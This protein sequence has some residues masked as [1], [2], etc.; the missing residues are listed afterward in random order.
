LDAT[1]EHRP[2]EKTLQFELEMVQIKKIIHNGTFQIGIYFGFNEE[3]KTKA[4]SIG[5][6]WSQTHRCWYVPYN[7]QSYQQIRITYDSIEIISGETNNRADGPAGT[8]HE[9]VRIATNNGELLPVHS[10]EHKGNGPEPK[11]PIEYMGIN[12]KYWILKVPYMGVTTRKL[13]AIKG[14]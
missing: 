5:A 10:E 6:R 12:G 2:I 1:I 11:A 9:T 13:M 14:V 8:Q 7:K 3:L 4:K